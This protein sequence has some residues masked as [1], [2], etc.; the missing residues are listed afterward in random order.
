METTH[1]KSGYG[2]VSL[3]RDRTVTVID[4]MNDLGETLLVRAILITGEAVAHGWLVIQ[5]IGRLAGSGLL[6]GITVW[7]NDKH[8]LYLAFGNQ[9]IHDIGRY[10]QAPAK[11]SRRRHCHVT[12]TERDKTGCSYRKKEAYK[13]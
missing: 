10:G 12:G 11:R 13:R 5:V 7:H 4:E 8:W 1:R 2:P 3:I 6:A 9:V